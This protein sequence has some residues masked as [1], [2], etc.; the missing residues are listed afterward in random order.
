[1][2]RFLLTMAA[3]CVAFCGYAQR[4]NRYFSQRGVANFAPGSTLLRGTQPQGLAMQSATAPV[5]SGPW[6]GDDAGTDRHAEADAS[7][8]GTASRD[9]A[10]APAFE[11]P[12]GFG[13]RPWQAIHQGFNVNLELSVMA[14]L[15]K[16]APHGAGFGQHLGVTWLSPLGSRGWV[17][18]GGYVDH[19]GWDGASLTGA[20]LYAELGW[21][22]SP[23]WSAYI[24]GQK[25]LVD[26]GSAGQWGY[27]GMGYAPY[28]DG[29]YGTPYYYN[30]MADKVGAGLRWTPN[31][32]FSLELSVER[33][34]LPSHSPNYSRQYDYPVRR[35][36]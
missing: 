14:G 18:A 34:W 33:D 36:E 19:L 21:Q 29:L 6:Q 1:M 12:L 26:S 8:A 27:Y 4:D 32:S 25:S 31:H 5:V 35:G 17:M 13:S 30:A 23:Q 16:G 20:G 3:L 9:T 22:F 24:Y 7:A 28:W 15:G 10:S 11:R 2:K